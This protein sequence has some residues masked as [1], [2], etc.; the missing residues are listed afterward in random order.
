MLWLLNYLVKT[1]L[2]LFALCLYYS[3]M[4]QTVPFYLIIHLFKFLWC[5]PIMLRIIQIFTFYTNDKKNIVQG[6]IWCVH[7]YMCLCRYKRMESSS[8][9]KLWPTEEEKIHTLTHTHTLKGTFA[10]LSY[11]ISLCMLMKMESKQVYFAIHI[12][13]CFLL[14]CFTWLHFADIILFYKLKVMATLCLDNLSE[15]FFPTEFAHFM[16]ILHLDNC[17]N[18]SIFINIFLML[19][20][21]HWSLMMLL[22]L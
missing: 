4:K 16:L 22:L 8:L 18:I 7:T 15:P 6:R 19:I 21:D 3:I 5:F 1:F 13:I 9:K 20:Y 17:C 14:L 12:Q 10:N 2:T 11:K